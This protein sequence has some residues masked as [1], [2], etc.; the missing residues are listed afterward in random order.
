M[1]R[2]INDLWKI[3]E[4]SQTIWKVQCPKGILSFKRKKDAIMWIEASEK[5]GE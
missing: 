2:K 4:G 3:R 1:K 5:G